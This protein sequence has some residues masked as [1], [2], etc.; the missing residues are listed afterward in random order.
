MAEKTYCVYKHTNK[1]NGKVY[2]GITRK[3]PLAR[4][5]YGNG[6]RH[7]A[8]FS[9]AIEKYGWDAFSHEILYS[10]L[11]EDEALDIERN[12]ISKYN[13]ANREFG[14]NIELGGRKRGATSEET[15][16]KLRQ[17]MLGANNH[18]Y[19]K[20]LSE[21][22]RRKLSEC[23]TGEKHPKWGTHH[24]EETRK[25]IGETNRGEKH[26]LYGKHHLEGTKKKMRE[27]SP[28]NRTVLCVETGVVY[29]SAR[30][31]SRQTGVNIAGICLAIKGERIKTSGGY[32]WQYIS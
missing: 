30:E 6:Y 17:R 23:N 5:E 22:T 8:H 24:S 12:L 2:I 3:K 28:K 19:G 27:S 31:A 14:Y 1:I 4:W 21:E 7:N 9:S 16:E 20:H 15:L 32:H 11:T 10:G 13:S 25:K 26:Y 18:N 29:P